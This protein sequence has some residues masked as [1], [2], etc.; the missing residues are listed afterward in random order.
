MNP[1]WSMVCWNKIGYTSPDYVSQ[2]ATTE[3]INMYLVQTVKEAGGVLHNKGARHPYVS[4]P[5]SRTHMWSLFLQS[6]KSISAAACELQILQLITQQNLR[7]HV[8]LY[9]YKDKCCMQLHIYWTNDCLYQCWT[10]C[11]FNIGS[12]GHTYNVQETF[13]LQECILT[14]TCQHLMMQQQL[15]L[16]HISNTGYWSLLHSF[17]FSHREKNHRM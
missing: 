15:Q 14:S 4:W 7:E 10:S 17:K 9:A 5:K 12:I 2:G 16:C 8:Y 11:T 1:Q 3:N 6:I 13:K